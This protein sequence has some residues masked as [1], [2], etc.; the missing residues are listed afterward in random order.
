MSPSSP[1]DELTKTIIVSIAQLVNAKVSSHK[2]FAHLLGIWL[3][4]C[5][6]N[7]L[8][9]KKPCAAPPLAPCLFR[10]STGAWP[11]AT[12]NICVCYELDQLYR[13]LMKIERYFGR[14]FYSDPFFD[15]KSPAC[16]LNTGRLFQQQRAAC[17]LART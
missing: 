11:T 15:Y 8:E 12:Q 10:I 7:I 2:V 5:L 3:F 9:I 6:S 4:L 17:P 13:Y 16:P 14:I 1:E